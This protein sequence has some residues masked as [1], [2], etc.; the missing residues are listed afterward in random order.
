MIKKPKYK[1]CGGIKMEDKFTET[2]L[3]ELEDE[4]SQSAIARRK[5]NMELLENMAMEE[6]L[7]NMRKK[8]KSE[9]ALNLVG[10]SSL[11]EN[12]NDDGENDRD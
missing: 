8:L 9:N 5:K 10:E 1:F 4:N 11:D 6:L 12:A 7:E 3:D 2:L